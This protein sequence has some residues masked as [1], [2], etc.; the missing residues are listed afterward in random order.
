M[1]IY[2]GETKNIVIMLQNLAGTENIMA[3]GKIIQDIELAK[4]IDSNTTYIIPKG[5]KS[6]VNIQIKIPKD[7]EVGSSY[8]VTTSFTTITGAS[9]GNFGF[10]S[11]IEHRIP[12]TIIG[13][14]KSPL[15]QNIEKNQ[16]LV[17][18]IA[19]ITLIIIVSIII[20]RVK[21]SKKRR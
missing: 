19:L 18:I 3:D 10:G 1:Q 16:W 9:S 2:P 13:K 7:V 5:A 15:M 12:I 14:P 21:S 17:Y 4:I 6:A 20:K 8:N 11:G